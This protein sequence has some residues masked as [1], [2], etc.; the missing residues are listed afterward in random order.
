MKPTSTAAMALCGLLFAAAATAKPAQPYIEVVGAT[1]VAA[2]PDMARI[3]VGVVSEAKTAKQALSAN[4]E[5]MQALMAVLENRG[6]A[7]VDVQTRSFDVAPLYDYGEDRR[8]ED[9]RGY[10]VAN[11]VQVRVREL[12]GLGPLLDAL[13]DSG[14]NRINGIAFDVEDTQEL[15]DKGRR[16]AVRDARSRADLY[17]E[18]AGVTLGRLLRL[19]E[20]DSSPPVPL[21]MSAERAVP[22]AE[23]E[24]EL[25]VRLKLRYEVAQ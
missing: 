10:R 23:G 8:R 19:E 9:L 20:L 17:A 14:A 12:T 21:R 1:T 3:N 13:V 18:A 11:Q 16:E 25:G 15:L 7:D 2:R 24:V 4:T 5:A 22:I 6:I